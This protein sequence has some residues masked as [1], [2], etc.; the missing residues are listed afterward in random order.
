MAEDVVFKVSVQGK[1]LGELKKEFADINKELSNARVG[2]EEY[3][4]T[5]EKLGNVKDEIGDLR[6]TINA[7]NPEGKVAAFQ[8]VAGK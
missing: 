7:L 4:K 8:N 3:Q 6:N 5:L 1:N 2:T